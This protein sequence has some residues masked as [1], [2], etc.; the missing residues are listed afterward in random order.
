MITSLTRTAIRLAN[1]I[2]LTKIVSKLDYEIHDNGRLHI[3]VRLGAA[4]PVI[5]CKVVRVVGIREFLVSSIPEWTT[6]PS[7]LVKWVRLSIVS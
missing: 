5:R 2:E 4:I 7:F 3:P 6:L 1:A